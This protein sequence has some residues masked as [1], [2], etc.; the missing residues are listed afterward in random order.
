MKQIYSLLCI[1]LFAISPLSNADK[2]KAPALTASTTNPIVMIET[3]MGEITVQLF[4]KKAPKTVANFLRYVNEGFYD[5]T[6]FHRVIPSFMIQGGGFTKDF[7]KKATHAPIINEANNRL[8]N[9]AGTLAM[10][11]TQDPN[12]ATAQFFINTVSNSFLDYSSSNYG[13]A[14]FGKVIA[15]MDTVKKIEFT[16]TGHKGGMR[17]A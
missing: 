13:Y 1:I 3:N 4:P 14:V 17:C 7:T 9:T 15:G 2:A 5:N 6:I 8:H 16:P 10:A 11:R 12:S